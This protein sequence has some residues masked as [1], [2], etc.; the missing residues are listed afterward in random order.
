[1]LIF[2]FYISLFYPDF[3]R[4]TLNYPYFSIHPQIACAVHSYIIPVREKKDF[5][6]I[7]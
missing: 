4:R 2:S 7:S 6:P 5:P 3:T 1:M